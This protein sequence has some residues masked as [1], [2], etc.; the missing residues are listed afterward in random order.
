MHLALVYCCPEFDGEAE[1]SSACLVRD[2]TS[3]LLCRKSH[4]EVGAIDVDPSQ[5]KRG[6]GLLVKH[7]KW[8]GRRFN[9]GVL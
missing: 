7:F 9:D 4:P 1:D 3:R 2:D 6:G 8:C 5:L